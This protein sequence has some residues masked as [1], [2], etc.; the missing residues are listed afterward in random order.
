MQILQYPITHTTDDGTEITQWIL[1]EE[2]EEGTDEYN[3]E[4]QR[5]QDMW[6]ELYVTSE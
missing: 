6:N 5:L 3:T 1:G 4:K 2:Y